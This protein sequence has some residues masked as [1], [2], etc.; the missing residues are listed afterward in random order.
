LVYLGRPEE[1]LPELDKA[2]RYDQRLA[3]ALPKGPRPRLAR[4][5]RERGLGLQKLGR[6][7]EAAASFR[8]AN[9]ILEELPKPTPDDLFY[10]ACG[11]ALL[12]GLALEKDSGQTR[13]DAD[14]AAEQ[15]L[16]G[17][18]LASAAGYRDLANLRKNTFLDSLRRRPDFEGLLKELE[19]KVA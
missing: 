10:G 7:P 16:A 11:H 17:L 9:A 15:A 14:A 6:F 18:R 2:L 8:E 3:A 1:A 4:L 13:A 5:L 19:E 12:H